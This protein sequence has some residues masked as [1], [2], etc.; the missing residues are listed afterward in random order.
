MQG[1]FDAQPAEKQFVESALSSLTSQTTMNGLKDDIKIYIEA[2]I[3]R[4][5]IPHT[6]PGDLVMLIT[7]DH[8]FFKIFAR[9]PIAE[10][11]L[12]SRVDAVMG[13]ATAT[14]GSPNLRIILAGEVVPGM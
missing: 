5:L 13:R 2:T 8:Q 11:I 14:V 7:E 4:R 1:E 10:N 9:S 6:A 12:L 3:A